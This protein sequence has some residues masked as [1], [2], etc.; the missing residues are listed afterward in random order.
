M[1]ICAAGGEKDRVG[2]P[3]ESG[4]GAA[5]GFLKVLADPPVVFGLEVA[6]CYYAGARADGEFRFGGGPAD[7]GS[8]AVDAQEDEGGFPACRGGFPDVGI[9]VCCGV[10][11]LLARCSVCTVLELRKWGKA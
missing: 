2:V 7:E 6:D 10:D 4:D 3:G 8:G 11:K 9:A 1:R 5:D